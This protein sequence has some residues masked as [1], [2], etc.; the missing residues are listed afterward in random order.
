M[1]L[2]GRTAILFSHLPPDLA[3]ALHSKCCREAYGRGVGQRF[4]LARGSSLCPLLPCSFATFFASLSGRSQGLVPLLALE[5]DAITGSVSGCVG[6]WGSQR[7]E[8]S[9]LL[10]RGPGSCHLPRGTSAHGLYVSGCVVVRWG[11]LHCR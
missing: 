6:G 1:F 2:Q 3:V 11:C 8:Q 5:A 4:L 10:N 7:K 9:P